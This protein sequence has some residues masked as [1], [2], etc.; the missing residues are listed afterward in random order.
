MSIEVAPK[1]HTHGA[2]PSE[3]APPKTKSQ[4]LRSFEPADFPALTGREEDWRYT[5]V[6][7]LAGLDDP[8]TAPA[9]KAAEYAIRD[10]PEGVTA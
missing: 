7:R 8:E 10:L 3:A 6:K 9:A 5:P 2:V 4:L 1:P